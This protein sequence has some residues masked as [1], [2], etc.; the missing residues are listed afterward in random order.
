M[1]GLEMIKNKKIN[2]GTT[3]SVDMNLPCI[4]I[5]TLLMLVCFPCLVIKNLLANCGAKKKRVLLIN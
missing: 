4:F 1:L 3:S 5:Y 2:M